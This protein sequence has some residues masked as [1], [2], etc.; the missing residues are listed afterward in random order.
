MCS[1][2]ATRSR[3][4]LESFFEEW[5]S[6]RSGIMEAALLPSAKVCQIIS[7]CILFIKFGLFPLRLVIH[8]LL[9]M[10]PVHVKHKD[11]SYFCLR[12]SYDMPSNIPVM[13][14]C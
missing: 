9:D 4:E 1:I 8:F 13:V 7:R 3:P 12:L 14:A 10:L 11:I 6:L 2:V 5:H